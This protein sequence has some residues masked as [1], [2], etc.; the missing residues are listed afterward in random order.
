M[1]A[2]GS[3]LLRLIRALAVVAALVGVAT[4]VRGL[5]GGTSRGHELNGHRPG[6]GSFDAWPPVPRAPGAARRP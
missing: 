2:A 3:P 1:A 6:R 5:I 4:A